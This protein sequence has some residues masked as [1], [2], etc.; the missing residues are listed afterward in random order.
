MAAVSAEKFRERTEETIFLWIFVFL[1]I[2]P[3]KWRY[4]EIKIDYIIIGIGA[5]LKHHIRTQLR[6]ELVCSASG[7]RARL[8]LIYLF[9]I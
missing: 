8:V 3:V 1:Q 6:L 9:L 7:T 4:I 5:N 2:I